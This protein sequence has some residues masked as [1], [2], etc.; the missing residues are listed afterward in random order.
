MILTLEFD[1]SKALL[2][3]IYENFEA[4][5]A[6]DWSPLSNVSLGA[7][8]V[9]DGQGVYQLGYRNAAG[10]IEL[11]YIGKTDAKA[12]LLTRLTR[13]A[14]KVS[15]RLNINPSDVFFKAIRVYVFTPMDLEQQ[16][17]DRYKSKKRSPIWNTSGF[18][19]NDP[20]R[21]RDTSSVKST[22]FDAL[23]PINTGLTVTLPFPVHT[24]VIVHDVLSFLKEK[25]SYLIR[26]ER[27][28][29]GSKTPHPDLLAATVSFTKLTDTI[30]N[31]LSALKP[32]LTNPALGQPWQIT[33]FPGYIIVYKE[34][35]SYKHGIVM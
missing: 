5:P 4:D 7:T 9:T 17:I 2:N 23:F 35:K 32:S 24:P 10:L 1:L 11:V 28:A 30:E 34:S 3:T 27:A 14:Q 8:G 22:H 6:L 19:S 13:H 33:R 12:G 26:F 21:E 15:H 20:G 18:G 31:I 29:K 16:L 25:V